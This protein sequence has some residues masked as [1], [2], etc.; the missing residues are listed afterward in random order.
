MA[1]DPSALFQVRLASDV[2][3]GLASRV[4]GCGAGGR[5]VGVGVG[6][7][8]HRYHLFLKPLVFP[9]S[10]SNPIFFPFHYPLSP[11]PFSGHPGN[12]CA[13]HQVRGQGRGRRHLRPRLCRDGGAASRGPL[14]RGSPPGNG[15]ACCERQVREGQRQRGGQ[16]EAGNWRSA[17]L[18]ICGV[19]GS[20]VIFSGHSSHCF[21]WG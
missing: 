19:L 18:L 3:S 8:I 20:S 5:L 17:P 10:L 11:L 9:L 4:E 13:T 2:P 6:W 1:R 16:A 15:L 7:A 12:D 14:V 21:N